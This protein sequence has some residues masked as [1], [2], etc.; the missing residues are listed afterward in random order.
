MR[1][2][3]TNL[4]LEDLYVNSYHNYPVTVV[5]PE[6]TATNTTAREERKRERSAVEKDEDLIKR[7][8][9]HEWLLFLSVTLEEDVAREF[10]LPSSR[11]RHPRRVLFE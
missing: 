1:R 10:S 2:W 8:V 5:T 9:L 4:T 3:E 6:I 7:L 11:S